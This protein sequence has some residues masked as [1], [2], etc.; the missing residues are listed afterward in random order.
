MKNARNNKDQIDTGKL[1]DKD[2]SNTK[3]EFQ[4]SDVDEIYL[5]E[6]FFLSCQI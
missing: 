6:S 4:Q 1:F 3:I 5:M 2:I